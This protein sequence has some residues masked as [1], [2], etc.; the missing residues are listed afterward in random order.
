MKSKLFPYW[1]L[2][3]RSEIWRSEQAELPMKKVQKKIL[4]YANSQ[5]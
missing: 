1:I 5:S 4:D 3:T 2:Q